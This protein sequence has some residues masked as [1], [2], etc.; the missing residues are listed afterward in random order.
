VRGAGGV[1]EQEGIRPDRA[2]ARRRARRI[3]SDFWWSISFGLQSSRPSP[4][5]ARIGRVRTLPTHKERSA[6]NGRAGSWCRHMRRRAIGNRLCDRRSPRACSTDRPLIARAGRVASPAARRRWQVRRE[7]GR[8]AACLGA[9]RHLPEHLACASGAKLPGLNVNGLVAGGD[10]GIA[11]NC[12]T[13][14]RDGARP[15]VAAG[16]SGERAG[17]RHGVF[18][19][20]RTYATRKPLMCQ[21]RPR[22]APNDGNGW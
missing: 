7:A 2:S 13:G 19:M 12:C 5:R 21:G 11:V 15:A 14:F 6:S 4:A 18:S 9:A 16:C 10:A 3:A 1:D 17:P 20:Q 8:V 22:V